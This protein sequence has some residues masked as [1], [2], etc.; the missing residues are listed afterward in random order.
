M[1]RSPRGARTRTPHGRR[2]AGA[3]LDVALVEAALD[4]DASDAAAWEAE[5]Q[6]SSGT[7]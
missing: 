1:R 2:R 5:Y 4:V 6:A 7:R 3:G